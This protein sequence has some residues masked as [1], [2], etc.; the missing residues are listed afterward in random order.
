M[1]FFVDHVNHEKNL[2]FAFGI[3]PDN[4]FDGPS[5]TLKKCVSLCYSAELNF[6][7]FLDTMRLSH[8]VKDVYQ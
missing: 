8:D 3:F 6:V 5:F 7:N 2:A 4:D 1:Q